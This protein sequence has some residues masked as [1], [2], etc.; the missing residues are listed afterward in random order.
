[1]RTALRRHLATALEAWQRQSYAGHP[2]PARLE[3]RCVE[4]RLDEHRLDRRRM[5]IPR[6][7]GQIEAV[8]Q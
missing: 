7:V 4:Q 5:E 6:H 8:S 1:M 3:H 2:A